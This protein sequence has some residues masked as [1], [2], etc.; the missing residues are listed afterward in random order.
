MTAAARTSTQG[1]AFLGVET[2]QTGRRWTG[3]DAATDRLAQAIAREAGLPEIVATLLAAR[4]V[5]PEEAGRYLDPKLRDLMPDPDTLADMDR[6]ARRLVAAVEGRQRIAV[7]ADYDVDGGASAALLIAWL[8]ELGREA[9]LYV[10]DRLEEGYGPNVPAME[11]LARNH[12]LILCVD[13]GT[14]SPDPVEAAMRAGA[15]VVIADHHLAPEVLPQ[16]TAIV[17]PNRHD[18][19]SG[20]GHLCAAGV[21]FL[22]LVAANRI[23]RGKGGPVPD[24]MGMLDLVAVATVAD[25][26]PLTGLNRAF[27]RQGLRVM[28]GRQRPGLAALADVAGLSAPPRSQDLGFVIGPRINA[29]GRVGTADLGA[30]LLATDNAD[31]AAALAERL[32]GLNAERRDIEA[33][34]LDAAVEQAEERG[35]AGGLVWAAGAGWHAGVVG[36]VAAR[37]KERFNRPAVVIG[38]EGGEGK[39]SGRSV[40]GVDLGSAIAA[41]AREGLLLRG[42]GHRMAAGLTV[43]EE[44]LEEAMAA[45]DARLAAQ[46]A[47]A[48]GPA[49]LVLSGALAPEAATVEVVEM[50]EAAGPF[51]PSN[52]APRLAFPSV[53]PGGARR[54]GSGGHLQFRLGPLAC[55]GFAGDRHGLTD[56]VE[57]AAQVRRPIHVAGRLELD[58][59][60]GRRKAKLRLEDAAGA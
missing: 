35:T 12:D 60:G 57:A 42:G 3:P 58:D 51:G 21:V 10:P 38:L 48:L 37:L 33:R 25:V 44:R 18:D 11:G 34:V 19:A 59:W 23:L 50:L 13:C 15:D 5:A 16:A 41:L 2:S 8:R 27:V 6:A 29:G 45:L 26:A 28:A 1:D 20:M 39:G 40:A 36:I 43:A 52:P 54:V 31:E 7:F 14:A 22:W 46:G 17:N 32:H 56:F 55:I 47:D 9:T 30:R 53:I 4:G 49:D 24:L